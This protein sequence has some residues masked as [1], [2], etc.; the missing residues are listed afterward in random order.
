ML[1]PAAHEPGVG[2]ADVPV[3]VPAPVPVPVAEPKLFVMPPLAVLP[4]WLVEP[5][6]LDTPATAID[7]PGLLCPEAPPLQPARAITHPTAT[8]IALIV[9]EAPRVG[10]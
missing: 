3:P 2:A 6:T 1:G 4:G 10:S 9:L 8:T 5:F 7:E